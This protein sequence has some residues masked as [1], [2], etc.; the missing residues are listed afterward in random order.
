MRSIIEFG[1]RFKTWRKSS[2]SSHFHGHRSVLTDVNHIIW[3]G[4]IM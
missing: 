1:R 2:L 3:W 4:H